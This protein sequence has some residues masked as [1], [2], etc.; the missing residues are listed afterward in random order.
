MDLRVIKIL[1]IL[2]VT[3]IDLLGYSPIVLSLTGR[4]FLETQSVFIND[5]S[6]PL[7]TTGA[8]GYTIVSSSSMH[9]E[10]PATM[11][12]TVI[13]KIVVFGNTSTLY[14]T[15]SIEFNLVG[16][17]QIRGISGVVQQ[18]L[19]LFLTTP[20]TDKFR[21]NSGGGIKNMAGVTLDDQGRQGIAAKLMLSARK[22]SEEIR[23]SQMS[24]YI[25]P[26][27]RLVDVI[28]GEVGFNVETGATEIRLEVETEARRAVIKIGV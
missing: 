22:C 15:S 24:G 1:D 17:N 14:E 10:L 25:L 11:T 27:E 23:A 26:E 21:R 3:R 18:F 4:S 16:L 8:H 9:V 20:G 7:K 6:M 28:I 5:V 2:P 13:N 19:K 12:D